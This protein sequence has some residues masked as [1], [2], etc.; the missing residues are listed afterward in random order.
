MD[1]SS[2][3]ILNLESKDKSLTIPNALSECQTIEG[4]SAKIVPC[5][6]LSR[7]QIRI[8]CFQCEESPYQI[9][10]AG[11]TNP[12]GSTDL[13]VT[14]QTFTE[15]NEL[16]DSSDAQVI[17][18]ASGTL[19]SVEML[20]KSSKVGDIAPLIFTMTTESLVPK[21]GKIEVLLPKLLTID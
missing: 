13:K 21:D 4:F 11:L 2:H 12:A 20:P 8:G 7:T 1:K 3:F 9:S 5:I 17:T 14:V 19:Q 15:D 10:I 16:I 18:F 6:K